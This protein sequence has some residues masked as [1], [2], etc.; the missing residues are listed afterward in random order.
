MWGDYLNTLRF[1]TDK[2]HRDL[3]LERLKAT[4]CNYNIQSLFKHLI[5]NINGIISSVC[6]STIMHEVTICLLAIH[7]I[8]EKDRRINEQFVLKMWIIQSV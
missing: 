7:N 6:R 2:D 1:S 3:S 4:I 5:Q 8:F